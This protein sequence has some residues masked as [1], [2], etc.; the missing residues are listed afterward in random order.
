VHLRVATYNI[1]RG[2]GLDLRCDLDRIL[3]ILKRI[4][5][6][7]LALQE[8]TTAPGDAA[9]DQP[10]FLAAAL[11]M[12]LVR[13]DVRPHRGGTYGH[14]VLSRLPVHD[15]ESHDLGVPGCEPRRCL[16][17]EIGTTAGAVHVF[18]C[19][20]GLG[21]RERR[22]QTAALVQFV[23]RWRSAGGRRVVL[24][25]FNEYPGPVARALSAELG[26]G[27]GRLRTHPAPLP[28]FPIDR[29]YWDRERTGDLSVYLDPIARLASDHLP[30]VVELD[31]A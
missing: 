14:A 16:H 21:I 6:D 19:H 20:F 13:C 18:G 4:D 30:L 11:D 17:V 5:A 7:V 25:D 1:Q 22:G 23:R 8:V 31:V 27:G 9:R 29:I 3:A 2:F 10:A 28:V 24:G 15:V 26:A 12:E